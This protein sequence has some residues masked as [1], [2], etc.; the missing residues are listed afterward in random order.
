M[1]GNKKGTKDSV[2]TNTLILITFK[3]ATVN[4]LAMCDV[5]LV[6]QANIKWQ[7]SLVFLSDA[8]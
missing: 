4:E 6:L 1:Y 8:E 7:I 3:T 5:E 2:S